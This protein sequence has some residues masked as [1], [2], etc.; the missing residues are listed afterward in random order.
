MLILGCA[1]MLLDM[2]IEKFI[3][4]Q[5]A[6]GHSVKTIE[7]YTRNLNLFYKFFG[8]KEIEE[9]EDDTFECFQ[10]W[11]LEHFKVKKLAYRLIAEQR[12][13]FCVG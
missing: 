5:E 13:L 8:N 9:I 10:R 11:L 2:A 12:K 3:F 7:Y 6:L 4:V 1:C